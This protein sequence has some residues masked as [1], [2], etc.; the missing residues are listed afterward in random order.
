MQS[1]FDLLTPST[2]YTIIK[3]N[4]T[5][6]LERGTAMFYLALGEETPCR[7][8]AADV[9]MRKHGVAHAQTKCPSAYRRPLTWSLAFG[10]PSRYEPCSTELNF[11][12]QTVFSKGNSHPVFCYMS[13]SNDEQFSSKFFEETFFCVPNYI[14]ISLANIGGR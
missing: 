9:A 1:A 10:H 8:I 7:C 14:I 4:S 13:F 12:E 5:K 11:G 2:L 6:L 3:S